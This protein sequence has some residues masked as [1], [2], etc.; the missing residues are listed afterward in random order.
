VEKLGGHVGAA[1]G[2]AAL[3]HEADVEMAPVELLHVACLGGQAV[4]GPT[5]LLGQPEAGDDAA[6]DAELLQLTQRLGVLAGPC[7]GHNPIVL[8]LAPA[9]RERPEVASHVV[10]SPSRSRSCPQGI[11]WP[12]HCGAPYIAILFLR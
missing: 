4:K 6:I 9:P 1:F 10:L 7:R 12:G 3:L 11:K 2:N 5:V 8:F